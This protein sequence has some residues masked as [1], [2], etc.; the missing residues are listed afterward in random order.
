MILIKQLAALMRYLPLA[1]YE[2]RVVG[3]GLRVV[4]YGLRDTGCAVRVTGCGLR[5]AGCGIRVVWCGDLD[6]GFRI[7]RQRAW[8]V[9]HGAW[10]MG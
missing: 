7:V 5:V 1:G 2:L 9:T 3:C 10:G 4:G 8:G 6:L